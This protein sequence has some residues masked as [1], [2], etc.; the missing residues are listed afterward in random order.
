MKKIIVLIVLM[1]LC[2]SGNA[3]ETVLTEQ[4]RAKRAEQ[5][6][7]YLGEYTIFAYCP[8]VACCGKSDHFTASGKMAVE[9]V[10]VACDM[11]FGTELTIEGVGE[12]IVQ[13]RGGAIY[14][15]CIDMFMESHKEALKFGVRKVK[16]WEKE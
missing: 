15:K 6:Y 8:C 9:G 12:R 14:G 3:A 11:E 7:K 5:P 16:V 4:N 1:F 13:D 2:F 10:T